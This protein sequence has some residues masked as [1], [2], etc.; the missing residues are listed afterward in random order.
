MLNFPRLAS[1]RDF[2][3]VF[4][5]IEVISTPVEF[6]LNEESF[7]SSLLLD[8]DDLSFVE[9]VAAGSMSYFACVEVL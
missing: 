5:W 6:S 1:V 4:T 9:G 7:F 2:I 3:S 8:I